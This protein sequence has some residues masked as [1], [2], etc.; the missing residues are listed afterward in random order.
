MEVAT[1]MLKMAKPVN[2]KLAA[3]VE[4]SVNSLNSDKRASK[5]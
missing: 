1:L 3:D 2:S 4:N 5:K